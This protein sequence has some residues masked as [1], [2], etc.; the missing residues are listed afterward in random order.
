MAY[1]TLKV[2]VFNSS[3]TLL[4]TVAQFSNLNAASGYQ[5]HNADL[6]AYIGK[7]ITLKFIGT[8]DSAYQTSFV[9]DDV[10]LNVQ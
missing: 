3:G 4:G 6:S 5:Q 10:S 8:E 2:Q 9:L 7:S 1:D